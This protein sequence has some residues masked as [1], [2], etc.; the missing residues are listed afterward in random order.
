MHQWLDVTHTLED[1][2]PVF[3]EDPRTNL[4]ALKTYEKDGYRLY[5]LETCLHAGTHIDVPLHMIQ[6]GTYIAS[7]T[8]ERFQ[9][10][11]ILLDVS[12]D[13][14][15]SGTV[16]MREA[17]RNIDLFDKI[18]I[19]KTGFYKHFGFEFYFS[20]YPVLE[21]DFA[22]FLCEQKIKI[23]CLDTPSPDVFPYVCHQLFLG[24]DIPMIE[25]VANLDSLHHMQRFWVYAFPLK[26]QAEAS[27]IRMVL[28]L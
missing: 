2:I 20:D 22:R 24:N 12:G 10:E 5:R 1:G 13:G 28:K 17:Y 27:P 3:G 23:L 7:Y 18:V 11:G 19:L 15:T 4:Y 21:D 14:I 9:G 16:K 25:N 8:V 6:T 26:I